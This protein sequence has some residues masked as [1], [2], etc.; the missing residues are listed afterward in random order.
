M[1]FAFLSG[2][3]LWFFD[4][5][6]EADKELFELREELREESELKLECAFKFE[7]PTFCEDLL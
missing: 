1:F 2:L 7:C 3:N 6:E 5:D 4:G